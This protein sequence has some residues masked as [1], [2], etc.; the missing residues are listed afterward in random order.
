VC[1]VDWLDF[2]PDDELVEMEPHDYTDDDFLQLGKNVSEAL[3]AKNYNWK[4]HLNDIKRHFDIIIP[5][6]PI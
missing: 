4:K 5:V 1:K 3:I 2:V 6:L